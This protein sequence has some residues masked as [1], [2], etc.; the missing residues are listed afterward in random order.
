MARS[1]R[2]ALGSR[3]RPS[4]PAVRGAHPGHSSQRLL[5]EGAG[6]E[7]APDRGSRGVPTGRGGRGCKTNP[8]LQSS[9]SWEER[10]QKAD[11]QTHLHG[12]SVKAPGHPRKRQCHLPWCQGRGR[13]WGIL[14]GLRASQGGKESVCNAGDAR[15]AGL[16]PGSGRSPGVGNGNPLQYA[17]LENPT[18]RGTWWAMVHRVNSC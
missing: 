3:L 8:V 1:G 15:D 6:S 5:P 9:K 4:H 17:C 13:L 18:D 14:A 2:P 12:E 11:A 7:T 10:P 16:I